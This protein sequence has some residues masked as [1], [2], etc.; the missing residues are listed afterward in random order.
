[1]AKYL[2]LSVVLL[3]KAWPCTA[4]LP[5]FGN[6]GAVCRLTKPAA[7]HL[8]EQTAQVIQAAF[9]HAD[10]P[11]I[12]G[13]KSMR[14][15]GKI[16]YGLTNIH[17]SGLS[18][19][20][21]SVD[22]QEDSAISI[23]IQ[24]VSASFRGTLS[25]GFVGTWLVKLIHAIEFE[26]DSSI[27]LQ[28]NV[29]L[30]CAKSRVVVDTSDCYLAFHK[31]A[32][33]LQG[34]K[35]PGWLKQL[36]TNFISF[37][38]KLVLK[39]QVCK[40]INFLAQMLADLFQDGAA[41]FLQDGDIGLDL[42]V[43]ASPVIKATYL[44]SHHKGLLLYKNYSTASHGTA[45]T[46]FLLPESRMLH[47]WF[48]DH[49]LNSLALA[50][51]LDE[52]LELTITGK[53]L[54]EIFE[55]EK[56]QTHQEIVQEIFQG[57]S[58][59]DS[60]AKVWSLQPPQIDLQPEGTLVRSSVAVKL[61]VSPEGEGPSTRL[62]FEKEVT[63]L[64]HASYAQK[65]LTLHQSHTMILPRTFKCSPDISVSE[66]T[67]RH[68]LENII[69]ITGIPKVV[70][71]IE[72]AVTSLLNSKGILVTDIIDPEIITEKG[73]FIVQMDFNIPHH[74]LRDFLKRSL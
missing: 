31:L 4:E 65:R 18:I 36:F 44:E 40:E 41:H 12:K 3:G 67:L 46:P 71:R 57:V 54:Q 42:S 8:N 66:E 72:A 11:D 2:V 5:S 50:A 63:A 53:E 45:F 59:N 14:F 55:S 32:L 49:V 25:Y 10:Y 9:Q 19:E 61:V 23:E 34:D 38:L 16:A 39:N 47:F 51:F 33:H 7:L 21:S 1:M 22:F 48:S 73:Y 29:K 26:I 60:T 35:D 15:V 70:S 62:Y 74:L 17:V 28:I 64:I 69:T 30:D 68:I 52:R 6:T 43:T 27:D 56:L 37:T 58:Y 24:N 13:E 20:S